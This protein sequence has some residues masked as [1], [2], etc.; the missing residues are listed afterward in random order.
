ML[1]VIRY[2]LLGWVYPVNS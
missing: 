2:L 1:L